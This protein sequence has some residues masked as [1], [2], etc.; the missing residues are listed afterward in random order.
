MVIIGF[1]PSYFAGLVVGELDT[2]LIIHIHAVVFSGWIILFFLQSYFILKRNL[3]LHMRMGKL[4]IYYGI[5][6]MVVGLVTSVVRGEF[7]D[8]MVNEAAAFFSRVT[9]IR[10]VIV[11]GLLFY[12]AMQFR[13]KPQIHKI[14]ILGAATYLL[15]PAVTRANAFLFHGN[16]WS[17]YLLWLLPVVLG[18]VVELQR[19]NRFIWHF[20]AMLALMIFSAASLGW[21]RIIFM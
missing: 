14:W 15:V 7:H 9:G 11:F 16:E 2:Q 12:L 4:G 18:L 3:S 1:W 17:F 5:L 19:G 8:E 13:N 21:L 10:D 6:I 20:A